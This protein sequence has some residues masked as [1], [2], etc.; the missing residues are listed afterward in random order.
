MNIFG[1]V[2]CSDC[3]LDTRFL[4]EQ[5]DREGFYMLGDDVD[6]SSQEGEIE[7]DY[8]QHKTT[9]TILVL[10]GRLSAFL[11]EKQL[12]LYHENKLQIKKASKNEGLEKEKEKRLTQFHL[13]FTTDF[14]KQPYELGRNLTL[15]DEKWVVKTIHKKEYVEKDATKRVLSGVVDQYYYEVEN[16]HGEKKWLNVVDDKTN[17]AILTPENPVLK[18]KEVL[19]DVTDS[20]FH[21]TKISDEQFGENYRI[22]TYEYISG[23]RLKVFNRDNEQE[24]DAFGDTYDEAIDQIEEIYAI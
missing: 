4:I 24:I 12:K 13:C 18:D 8:C 22:E 10:N 20:G 5:E 21:S 11:N 23:I 9:V 7:C 14:K 6:F 16:E 3:Q 1:N 19:H 17:N 15:S 2:L